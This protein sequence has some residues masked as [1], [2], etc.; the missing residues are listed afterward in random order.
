MLCLEHDNHSI[1]KLQY[2]NIS[3]N[4]LGLLKH[5]TISLYHRPV[6]KEFHLQWEL[7][8]SVRKNY[9]VWCLCDIFLTT[10]KSYHMSYAI[11]TLERDICS[12]HMWGMKLGE[13]GVAAGE[14]STVRVGV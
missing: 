13:V 11:I 14:K 7:M 9:I 4:C 8:G 12:S 3:G 1:L 2:P 10:T 6:S 5:E